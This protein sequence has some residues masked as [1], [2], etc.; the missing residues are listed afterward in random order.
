MQHS[1]SIHY[2][3]K[4]SNFEI[5]NLEIQLYYYIVIGIIIYYSRI[6]NV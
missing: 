2:K 1:D 6:N 5:F 4:F 3:L